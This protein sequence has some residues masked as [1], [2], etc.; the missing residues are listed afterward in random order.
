[1]QLD[2][3]DYPGNWHVAFRPN[4]QHSFKPLCVWSCFTTLSRSK[5]GQISVLKSNKI[6]RLFSTFYVCGFC[7]RTLVVI[8]VWDLFF[9]LFL[10]IFF[11]MLPIIL[12]SIFFSFFSLPVP[13]LFSLTI[14]DYNELWKSVGQSKICTTFLRNRDF[15]CNRLIPPVCY[16]GSIFREC[17]RVRIIQI[18]PLSVSL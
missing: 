9:V 7:F 2:K 10:I 4:K 1:M 13:T 17:P 18:A 6:K 8:L 5:Q 11:R 15:F 3:G 16:R 12:V 14:H